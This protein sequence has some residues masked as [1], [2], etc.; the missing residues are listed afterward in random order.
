[1]PDSVSLIVGNAILRRFTMAAE[2]TAQRKTVGRVMH[3]FNRGKL[4]GL[5]GKV[6]NPKQAIAI[7]LREAGASDQQSPSA[8]RHHLAETKRKERSGRTRKSE[9]EVVPRRPPSMPR[10]AGRTSEAGLG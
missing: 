10:P 9:R 3:A 8:N 6:R 5:D 2:T 4:E 1:M 7:A